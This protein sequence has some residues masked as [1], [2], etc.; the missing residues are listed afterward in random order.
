MKIFVYLLFVVTMLFAADTSKIE[1]TAEEKAYI[2]KTKSIKMCVDPD[3]VPFERINEK[4]EHE[5]IAA[6][7]VQTVADRVG[8]K[9]ELYPVKTW[10]ESLEASKSG[11]CQ[12]MSFLN[13]TPKREV[14]LIFTEP[15]FYDPNVFITREEHSFIADPAG[16]AGERIALPTG[17]MVEERIRKDY[18]NLNVILTKNEDDAI[19]LVSNKKADMTMRS[20][21]VAAYS[22]KKEGLFNLKIAGQL[23]DYSNKLRIGVLKDD[24]ILRDIL[25]KGVRTLTPQEREAISNKHVSIK[26]ESA[27]SKNTIVA[28]VT[29]FAVLIALLSL[30]FLWNYQL[31]KQ[32]VKKAAKI[33]EAQEQLFQMSKKAEIGSLV[34]SISHQWRDGIVNVNYVNLRLMGMLATGQEISKELL[35]KSTNEIENT[36]GFMSE[37]MQSFLEYYKPTAKLEDFLVSESIE[38]SID[39]IHSKIKDNN[40]K[41]TIIDDKHLKFRAIKNEWMQAW[42]G[43]INNSIKAAIEKKI[44]NPEITIEIKEHSVILCDNCGGIDSET[45]ERIQDGTIGGLGLKIC[46]DIAEK[47]S[48]ELVISNT[49]SGA[50]FTISTKSI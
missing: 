49:L 10:E 4:G 41:L 50:C 9:I 13:Q 34:A 24:R 18:P 42:L 12:I 6:D 30:I 32:V 1:F 19:S 36:L 3:W 17:T 20:L 5:G 23:P 37:T 22:I 27:I 26:V 16:F 35:E 21:I 14:W 25:D 28:V 40:V 46:R 15:I 38:K 48:K 39:I 2:E 8:L 7:L 11:K 44:P 45:L 31:K 47:Y 29:I 43:L 33:V